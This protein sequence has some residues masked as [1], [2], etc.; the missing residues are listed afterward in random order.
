MCGNAPTVASRANAI[1]DAKKE[2]S[3]GVVTRGGGGCRWKAVVGD[4]SSGRLK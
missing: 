2:E 1:V 4:V 3:S